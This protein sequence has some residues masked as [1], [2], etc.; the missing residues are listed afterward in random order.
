MDWNG[1]LFRHFRFCM[2]STDPSI[3][4]IR[5]RAGGVQA[6]QK[7]PIRAG[8][9]HNKLI[10][11]YNIIFYYRYV[12]NLHTQSRQNGFESRPKKM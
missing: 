9:I 3:C 10:W 2:F 4:I 8:T 5:V 1:Y 12:M 6:H 7:E 11:Y